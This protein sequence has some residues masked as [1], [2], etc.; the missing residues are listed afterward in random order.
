MRLRCTG[1]TGGSTRN[2]VVPSIEKPYIVQNDCADSILV[3]TT[4]GTGITVPAGKTM[5]VYSDGT[6]VVNTTTHLSSLTLGTDLAVA[7]GGTGASTF[8]TNGVLL[9]NGTSA[10]QV[11]AVGA[12]GQVLVGNTGAAPS[13]AAL[14]G[15]GVTSLSFGSTGL[16]PATATTGAITVAGTLG[17]ANG[18]TGTATAFTAGSVVFA[19]ASGVYTQDNANFFWDDTNNRLGIGTASPIGR[20]DV[21]GFAYTGSDA[22][23]SFFVN[24]TSSLVTI[25]AA[26]R[27]SFSTSDLAFITSNGSAS[28][29]R[30]RIDSAGNVGIGTV[31]PSAYGKFAVVGSGDIANFDTPSG[32]TGIALFENGQGRARIRTLDGVNGLGFFYGSTEGMRLNNAGNVGIGTSAPG[33]RLEVSG[34]FTTSA[35]TFSF[36]TLGRFDAGYPWA[37]IRPGTTATGIEF[38]NNAGDQVLSMV[39]ATKN[40]GI[41]A[42][43]PTEKLQI[44]VNTGTSGFENGFLLTNG[45]DANLFNYVT[46]TAA[47]DK[48]ALITV[49]APDQALT[50]GTLYTERMRIDAAGNVGIGT[51]IPASY[52]KLAVRGAINAST[53]G[54]TLLTMRANANATDLSAY[55]ATG[56]YLAFQTTPNGGGELER[57][58]ITADGNIGVGTTTPS[59]KL[60]VRGNIAMGPSGG[61]SYLVANYNGEI[62]AGVDGSGYYY[63]VGNGATSNIP[64]T[65]GDRAS[66]IAFKTSASTIAGD[67][68]MRIT[69]AGNVGIGTG[70]PGARLTVAGVAEALRLADAA[71][72]LSFYNAAQSIRLGY[73]QHTGFSLA[74]YN[75]LP[76]DLEFATN[77]IERMRI[78][79]TGTVGIGTSVPRGSLSIGTISTSATTQTIHMG[80]T[81]G[82]FYGW[83]L[84]ATNT[85]SSTAAGTFN[86]Q[87]GN[88]AEWVNAVTINNSGNVGIG[89]SSPAAAF[90]LAVGQAVFSGGD[91]TNLGIQVKVAPLAAIP[92]AQVQGYIATGD[93]TIGV[94][95]DLLI[96][97]RTDVAANI[98]FITGTTPAERMRIDSAGDVGIGTTAPEKL[99]SVSNAG[100]NGFEIEPR[101]GDFTRLIS[102]NRSTAAYTPVLLEGLD[103][104]FLT[105]SGSEV[106]RINSSGNVGIGTSTPATWLDIAQP[107]NQAGGNIYMGSKANNFTKYTALVSTQYAYTAEPEGFA[108]IV[109][110]SS[111][112]SENSVRIGGYIAELNAATDIQF[113]TAANATTRAGTERM[114]IDSSGNVGIGTSSP[115]RKLDVVGAAQFFSGAT[116]S[117]NFIDVGR[118][119][120]EARVAAAAA[121]G[122][123]VSGTAAGDAVFYNPTAAN[124]WFGVA[125]AGAAIFVT[126]SAERARF[127]ANGNL[128][129]GKTVLS[130]STVG[131]QVVGNTSSSQFGAIT[132]TLAGTTN[133]NT[134]NHVYSTGASAYR[135]YVDMA[136]TIYATSTSI[137][138][139][140]DIRLKENVRELDAGLDTILALK[141]RRF[142]WKQ[143][144]GKDVRDDM[145]FI[146]QEVEEVLPELIGGWKAGEGEPDDLKSVKAGDLIPVLVKA[147]QE[148]TARVAQLEERK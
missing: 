21:V 12:T 98:R 139:I 14:S 71:P 118:V 135:F 136:G 131:F 73:I 13:W 134:T 111:S 124:A 50:F 91:L 113:Y 24:S 88:S 84:A 147:I 127:D 44:Q 77:D 1:V 56:A 97:P 93:S 32:A 137:T 22:N 70:T 102:Y 101:E 30:M 51:A 25:G 116:G 66:H 100:A 17:V 33:A 90:H 2:L 3:K 67:E 53:D 76:G 41:G 64:I 119:A 29:E 130:D 39:S 16:T 43:S 20:L 83:R 58:R 15:I 126:N 8:T 34:S 148:L 117:L 105:G 10:I 87:R 132:S 57:V 63:G 95:G 138:A 82:D 4:A 106:M 103:L 133:A 145:G 52:G 143:G 59:Q 5:W 99:L 46:G 129:V 89:T 36:V 128:F 60:D 38:R 54:A 85:P 27:T 49:G 7:D 19:G 35:D 75:V 94:A 48:R 61:N 104:R 28:V 141:P 109:T 18:G 47:T 144:K 81:A 6:N 110:Q 79:S 72:Y 55:N 108:M 122:E 65:I 92:S 96:A 42:S 125:G 11:T 86:I 68:R 123:F 69:S 23:N 140:S 120:S 74:L 107:G 142:D 112:S 9:G 26:G 40:I 114:R 45:V 78:T 121:P 146:A 31:S 115:A 62:L 37:I 80:Y